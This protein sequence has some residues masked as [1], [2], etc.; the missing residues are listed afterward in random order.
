MHGIENRR[1]EVAM[2][3]VTGASG[4]TGIVVAKT[5]L[6]NGAK[7]RVIGRTP[8]HLKG[9]AAEGAEP[10]AADLTDVSSVTEAFAGARG[11]Y[12]MMPPNLASP[13]FRA[14]QNRVADA[15][16]AGIKASG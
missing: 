13:D 4:H 10:F 14:F 16:A 7:V 15:I 11:V 9:L 2:Y 1:M 8:Q 5:L 3:V 6:K 12:V